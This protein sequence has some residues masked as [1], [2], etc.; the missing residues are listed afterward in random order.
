MRPV[1]VILASD[2]FVASESLDRLRAEAAA[3]GLVAEEI[4]PGDPQAVR[5]ALDTPSLFGGGRFVL[6]RD[7]HTLDEDAQDAIE[8][9]AK[10][11]ADGVVLALMASGTTAAKLSKRFPA[12]AI[13]KAESVPPWKAAEWA[14]KRAKEKG[15]RMSGPA[16]AALVESV[17]SDLRDLAAAI[18]RLVETSKA[19]TIE[20][21]Q[22]QERFTGVESKVYQF[23]DSVFDRDLPLARKRLHGLLDQGENPIGLLAALARQLR[24]IAYVSGNDGR[25]A[26]AIAKD[27][28][29]KGEG[30]VKRAI[31]QARGFN[32]ARIAKAYRVMAD[33][34]LA[35]KSEGDD[36]L[37]LE[38]VVD[39]IAAR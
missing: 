21:D 1:T 26:A 20:L 33:A 39:E 7:A 35:M 15:R 19:A 14:V 11:P 27:L 34:D 31:R 5:Y 17:G 38:L 22:V 24:V 18:D 3:E 10:N 2:E 32:P 6:V 4:D 12:G 28:G 36:P 30:A 37:V 23:V 9:W 13:I 16:A 25:Q 8:A 29:L